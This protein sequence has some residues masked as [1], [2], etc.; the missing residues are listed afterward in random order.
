MN[1]K[2][3]ITRSI[4][5]RIGLVV[6]ILWS[7]EKS[8]QS[9]F[10]YSARSWLSSASGSILFKDRSLKSTEN[11]TRPRFLVGFY[12]FGILDHP[13][14][15][16]AEIREQHR[17]Y[18]ELIADPRICPLYW[19]LDD[20][21]DPETT[22]T[23]NPKKDTSMCEFIYT[24]VAGFDNETL[25]TELL[26]SQDDTTT[27]VVNR[28]A[29]YQHIQS[30]PQDADITILNIRENMSEGKSATWFKYASQIAEK[31]DF[32]Y[33][34][35][36][37]TDTY[38]L[39]DLFFDFANKYLPMGGERIYAGTLWDKA[40]WRGSRIAPDGPSI[41]HY[42]SSRNMIQIYMMGPFYVLS[43]DLARWVSSKSILSEPW[44]EKMED[45][46][47]G[48]RVFDFPEP[49]HVIRMQPSQIFWV[50]PAKTR[51]IWKLV[52]NRMSWRLNGPNIFPEP[53]EPLGSRIRDALKV[54]DHPKMGS[55]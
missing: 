4:G 13:H 34:I 11:R 12:S 50:H 9:T 24:F 45:H 47:V 36:A 49:L 31:Y 46:D 18:F 23:M 22:M 53:Q 48:M 10:Q 15:K 14:S 40:F 30:H 20:E 21:D 3:F 25:P 7:A 41:V 52:M 44:Y 35:K 38:I 33:V 26:P 39:T 27:S 29:Y 43:K 54:F 1:R 5:F 8:L 55:S 32:D 42:L 17:Q 51:D 37:D 19:F 6:A 2:A 28:E 16:T